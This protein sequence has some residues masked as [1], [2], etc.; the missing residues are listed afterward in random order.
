MLHSE[1]PKPNGH[2]CVYPRKYKR[3]FRKAWNEK[4]GFSNKRKAKGWRKHQRK[5][6]GKLRAISKPRIVP[7]ILVVGKFS[8]SDELKQCSRYYET[9]NLIMNAEL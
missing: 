4:H 6:L 9:N 8:L 5:L 3:M 1:I 7:T 2:W